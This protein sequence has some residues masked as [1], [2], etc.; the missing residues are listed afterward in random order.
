MLSSASGNTGVAWLLCI[1]GGVFM[2]S[3][4]VFIKVPRVVAAHVNPIIFQSY[5]SFWVFA[6]AW[7]FVLV[8]YLR[9]KP[10]FAFTWW[11]VAGAAIWVPN[12]FATIT[13]VSMCGVATTAVFSN[14]VSS[15]LQFL[16]SLMLDQT[17]K[18]HGSSNIPLAPF[19]LVA[20]VLGMVGLIFSPRVRCGSKADMA[21]KLNSIAAT[22]S[23]LS[24]SIG[25]EDVSLLLQEEPKPD[26]SRGEF[27]LGVLMAISAGVLS[28]LK[29]TVKH[30]GQTLESGNDMVDAQFGVF[31]SYMISFGIGCAICQP[32]Y[33]ALFAV[34][35]KGIQHKELPSMEFSVMK[36][37]GT[38]AGVIWFAAYMCQQAA[39]DM[40]GQ[41][42]MG[43][44]SSAGHLIVAGLWGFLYYREM[45]EP[46]Q[47][48]CWVL[49][50]AWT[51]A[52]VL[53]L[54]NELEATETVVTPPSWYTSDDTA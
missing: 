9:S 17:M 43:P 47:I 15:V 35:Q 49:S 16:V 22:T 13:A 4:P 14:S 45:K 42:A 19:Y 37:Y 41:G 8:N 44:A 48:A 30:I 27:A 24:M 50:A 20:V 3:Y 23:T 21:V 1:A 28:A 39:N 10:L 32:L 54:S 18:T 33:M 26:S 52:F 53:L 11:G 46:A 34:W 51:I 25:L 6:L 38:L 7:I 29:Y 12:G 31:E 2:G 36:I 5:K 40:G